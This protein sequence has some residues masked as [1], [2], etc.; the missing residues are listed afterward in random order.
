VITDKLHRRGAIHSGGDQPVQEQQKSLALI[1]WINAILNFPV[2]DREPP[3]FA[4][5]RR[6]ECGPV[7]AG[8]R[9]G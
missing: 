2:D 3:H 7:N 1:V 4:D 5:H 6:E 8:G 9:D